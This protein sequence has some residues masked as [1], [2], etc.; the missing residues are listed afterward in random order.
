MLDPQVS[1]ASILV[2][3]KLIHSLSPVMIWALG[4]EMRLAL[5]PSLLSQTTGPM[6]LEEIPQSRAIQS[7]FQSLR[8][9]CV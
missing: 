6:L 8:C 9:T 7:H 3:F 2:V 4:S 5:R 1:E